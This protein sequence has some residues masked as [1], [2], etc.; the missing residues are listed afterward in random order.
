M[1]ENYD[2]SPGAYPFYTGLIDE[3]EAERWAAQLRMP[4]EIESAEDED[5]TA[6]GEPTTD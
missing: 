1:F 4:D 6:E 3:E 5:D 2:H